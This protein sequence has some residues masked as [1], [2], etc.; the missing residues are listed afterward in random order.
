MKVV[1]GE[2]ATRLRWVRPSV[3]DAA[4]TESFTASAI[5]EFGALALLA[6]NYPLFSQFEK[7]IDEGRSAASLFLT[8]LAP[9][10]DYLEALRREDRCD[11]VEFALGIARLKQLL[12]RYDGT[13]SG[14]VV[15]VRQYAY[16]CAGRELRGQFDCDLLAVL[17]RAGGWDVAT[18]AASDTKARE[19]CDVFVLTMSAGSSPETA[20]RDIE[21]ARRAS[22][23]GMIRVMAYGAIFAKDPGLA[24]QIGADAAAPDAR[25]AAVVARA[26]APARAA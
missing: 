24:I 19:A 13:D 8:L 7:R 15:A 6:G 4:E 25:T 5:A 17:L 9:T 20:A 26:L 2:V 3:P 22:R 14:P 12:A 21:A 10:A 11:F 18:T 23:N 16:L 1:A